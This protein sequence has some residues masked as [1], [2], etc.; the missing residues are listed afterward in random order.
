MSPKA[1]PRPQPASS[2]RWLFKR[3]QIQ[4]FAEVRVP[5]ATEL[6]RQK[7]P[8]DHRGAC[9]PV[10]TPPARSIVALVLNLNDS[11]SRQAPFYDK[12][13]A[14]HHVMDTLMPY[15]SEDPP[16]FRGNGSPRSTTALAAFG[17]MSP[18]SGFAPFGREAS[19][20]SADVCRR[21]KSQRLEL[22][23]CG[24]GLAFTA[25][26]L[27]FADHAHRLDARNEHASA[28]KCLEP[29]HRS[30]NTFDHPAVLLDD[31]VQILDL[32]G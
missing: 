29:Q 27:P 6:L 24:Q 23:G 14:R 5:T 11:P 2:T 8:P 32:A 17:M 12:A 19:I 30:H 7:K 25:I 26:E 16:R 10:A 3:R 20:T 22:A 9:Y 21:L 13:R 15:P 4:R 28:A 31:V 18:Q 1:K